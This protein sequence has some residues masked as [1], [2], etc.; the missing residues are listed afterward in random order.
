MAWICVVPVLFAFLGADEPIP[1]RFT[2][3][4]R[5]GRQLLPSMPPERIFS[6]MNG[7]SLRYGLNFY[8]QREVA[9]WDQN[10]D[11]DAFFCRVRSIAS[12]CIKKGFDCVDILLGP[13]LPV[14]FLKSHQETQRQAARKAGSLTKKKDTTRF[15]MRASLRRPDSQN[16]HAPISL[17]ARSGPSETSAAGSLRVPDHPSPG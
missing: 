6:T 2:F 17:L 7:R 3:I 8:L 5:T 13:P 9:D 11:A 4:E 16:F 12:A 10:L 14:V 1:T 15:C